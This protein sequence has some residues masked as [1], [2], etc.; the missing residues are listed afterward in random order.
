V[1]AGVGAKKS[2]ILPDFGA[3]TPHPV[4]IR[5]GILNV[6]KN[7][8]LM[9]VVVTLGLLFAHLVVAGEELCYPEVVWVV[10]HAEKATIEGERNPPLTPRGEARAAA[11]AVLLAPEQPAAIYSTDYLRTRG[12]VA[13][14]AQH[15]GVEV[16]VVDAGDTD[17]LVETLLGDHCGQP[18]VVVGHSNTV[19]A[20][21]TGLGVDEMI[22]LD[23]N[24]GYGDLFE[25][26]WDNGETRLERRRF[27]D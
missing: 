18:I 4:H 15:T 26:R 12:T 9:W 10:R 17:S 7:N 16:T 14:L 5:A 1:G 27:G 21:I 24:T 23:E 11:L 20:L 8:R 13:P 3:P 6:M 22:V 25:V 2:S 19:P